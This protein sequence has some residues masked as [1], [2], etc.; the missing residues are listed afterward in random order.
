MVDDTHDLMS[1]SWPHA[2]L[3][4]GTMPGGH[5]DSVLFS[6]PPLF[7][8]TLKFMLL[9]KHALAITHSESLIGWILLTPC[10][11]IFISHFSAVSQILYQKIWQHWLFFLGCGEG[12]TCAKVFFTTGLKHVSPKF[13][14]WA[15]KIDKLELLN[16]TGSDMFQHLS[17]FCSE[18]LGY[19][20]PSQMVR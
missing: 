3:P 13:T 6:P 4:D 1:S 16:T 5:S 17:T 18:K 2:C 12:W 10:V 14:T 20:L 15:A 9:V 8:F 7:T 19:H 11:W